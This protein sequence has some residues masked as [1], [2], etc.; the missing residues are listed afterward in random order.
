MHI[1]HVYK[2]KGLPT[3]SGKKTA[4]EITVSEGDLVNLILNPLSILRS[5]CDKIQIPASSLNIR[6]KY[7][8]LWKGIR[9]FG[10]FNRD[11]GGD[12]SSFGMY[13]L[14]GL[15]HERLVTLKS[16]NG[17]SDSIYSQSFNYYQSR[18]VSFSAEISKYLFP[19]IMS[20]KSKYLDLLSKEELLDIIDRGYDIDISCD[21]GRKYWESKDRSLDEYKA[22]ILSEIPEEY[23]GARLKID[24]IQKLNDKRFVRGLFSYGRCR[25]EGYINISL[26]KVD[27]TEIVLYKGD[28]DNHELTLECLDPIGFPHEILWLFSIYKYFKSTCRLDQDERLAVKLL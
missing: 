17:G 14:M 23:F 2:I 4:G 13:S 3:K 10:L 18:Q 22:Y 25:G 27:G 6:D 5:F 16:N 12:W 26:I 11:Q 24:S 1:S 9:D 8:H 15:P 28:P 19:V 20:N 21:F 7:S